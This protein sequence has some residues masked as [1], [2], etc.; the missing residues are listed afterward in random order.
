VDGLKY[1]LVQFHLH[2]P[3]EH[4]LDGS[5]DPMELHLVHKNAAGGLAVV[6]VLLRAGRENPAYAS[7]MN[8]LPEREMNVTPV[9]AARVDA[10]RLLPKERTHWRYLGSLTTPPCTEGVTWLVMKMPVE[11]SDAQIAAFTSIF[12]NNARPV[13]GLNARRL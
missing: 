4:T 11:L 9:G 8:N 2:A 12:K 1:D 3:S 6:A 13:Q 5:H 10:N 7:V